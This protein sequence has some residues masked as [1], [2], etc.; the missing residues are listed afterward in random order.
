MVAK[1]G[2]LGAVAENLRYAASCA[3][4]AIASTAGMPDNH[5]RDNAA[6]ELAQA[7][8]LLSKAAARIDSCC[9]MSDPAYRG[10]FCMNDREPTNGYDCEDTSGGRTP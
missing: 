3:R 1:P 9:G 10:N 8:V 7:V 4:A 6:S 5:E 2:T